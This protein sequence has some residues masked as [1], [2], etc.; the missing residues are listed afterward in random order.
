MPPFRYQG[1]KVSGLL[2]YGLAT[3]LEQTKDVGF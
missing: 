2:C 1:L 3:I